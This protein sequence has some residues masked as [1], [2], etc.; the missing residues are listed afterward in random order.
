MSRENLLWGAPLS[1]CQRTTGATFSISLSPL[2][3]QQNGPPSNCGDAF[4]W[5]NAP[6]YLLRDRDPIFGSDLVEQVKAI[7]IKQVLSAPRSHR[8]APASHAYYTSEPNA[9][10]SAKGYA[11]AAPHPTTGRRVDHRDP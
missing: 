6:R 9:L 7:G 4:P 1:W 5:D 8:S 10:G 3:Q 11:R 2:I